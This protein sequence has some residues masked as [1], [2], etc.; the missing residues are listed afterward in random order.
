MVENTAGDMSKNG[1]WK[2]NTDGTGLTR[3]SMDTDNAQS[4]CPYSQYAWSNTSPDQNFYALQ[5]YDQNSHTY[6]MYYGSLNGRNPNQFA[7]ISD[8]TQLFLAGWT[9]M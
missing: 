7:D 5:S 4:L 8:G 1:L 9:S 2:I 3:L 6:G